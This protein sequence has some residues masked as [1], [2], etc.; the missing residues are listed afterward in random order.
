MKTLFHIL[1]T[2]FILFST[3][4]V[5]GQTKNRQLQMA[6]SLCASLIQKNGPG[7]AISV[8]QNGQTLYEHQ[9][10]YANLE[11][12]IPITD[13]SI[14]LVGS[15]SKQFTA[16]S[17]LLLEAEGKVSLED[18]ISKYLPELSGK[19]FKITLRQLANHTSGYRESYD[20][21]AMRGMG[22]EHHL[23]NQEDVVELLLQQNDLNFTP[24]DRFQYCNSGY[25]L[26]AEIV[27]RVSEMP[28]EMFVKTRIF[29]PLGMK[30]S[31]FLSNGS[32]V[33]YNKAESYYFDGDAYHRMPMNRSV[34]GSTGLYTTSRDLSIWAENFENTRV[35]SQDIVA[36]M[37]AN[38]ILNSGEKIPYG[39]GIETKKYKGLNVVFHGGGDVG[40]RA[41]LLKVPELNF[42]VVVTGNFE[43]FNPLDIAYGMIDVFL[44]EEI[45][46]PMETPLPVYSTE[47][48]ERYTGQYQIFPGLFIQ[49]LAERDTLFFQPFGSTDKAELPMIGEHEFEF[50]YAAKSKIVF[51][52]N[53]LKWHFSDFYYPG[54]RVELN[55]PTAEEM[56]LEAYVGTFTSEEIGTQYSFVV[57]DG[58]LIAE[59]AINPEITLIPIGKD[60][61]ITNEFYLGKIVFKRSANGTIEGCE[62]SGQTAYAVEFVK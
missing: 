23:S 46:E 37:T 20:L 53:G 48:L 3:T 41:Y 42:S 22:E 54:K 40:Y 33:I 28:F 5:F 19:N 14:F 56:N 4:L 32:K 10:G 11:N 31:F 52:D 62:I 61:F 39:L 49:I 9:Q 30:D 7:L 2:T 13:S 17:I 36:K 6:E 34:M 50:P 24:G 35:G 58:E 15:I 38:G 43:A 59:H 47:E 45:S 1:Q 16:F 18:D 55:V 8:V 27:S 60:V 57:R 29:D 21:N 25:V 44:K 26:L 51:S 12:R